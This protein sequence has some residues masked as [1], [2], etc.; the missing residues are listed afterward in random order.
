M[1]GKY[2]LGRKFTD[3][4]KR[5]I[6]LA[7]TGNINR[8][9]KKHTQEAREKM[10]LHH[11]GKNSKE[12][13]V[14][15]GLGN[16]GK[17]VSEESKEKIR[18]ARAKQIITEET[19]KKI[20]ESTKGKKRSLETRQKMSLAH[21]KEKSWKWKGGITKLRNQ[22]RQCFKYRLW[23]SDVFTKDNFTCQKCGKR[24][25]RIEADHWPKSFSKIF[26]ENKI[27]TLE[28]AIECEEFWNINNGR[29]LCKE[30]HRGGK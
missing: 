14:K 5:K 6:S 30:C 1:R 13:R 12:T 29:T 3:E 22:I 9:G 21:K 11:R 19:K 25:G 7:N 27:K 20:S 26:D 28:Q 23:R 15:I 4:H 16:K 8:K 24:G 10:S 18:K 17:R 2:W